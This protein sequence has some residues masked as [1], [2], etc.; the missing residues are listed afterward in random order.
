[1]SFKYQ[2]KK[3]S[4]EDRLSYHSSRDR[5]PG[6]FGLKYG[7][8]KHCYSFGFVDG[9]EHIDNSKATIKEFGKRA[10][11]AYLIGN[12]RGKKAAREYFNKTGKQ[13]STLSMK[14]KNR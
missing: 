8:T 2:T 12:E 1:M 11:K 10:G 9:F 13:P 7:G 6:R 4:L 5:S 14:L 3:Y